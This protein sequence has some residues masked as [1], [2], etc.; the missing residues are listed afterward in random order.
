MAQLQ[1]IRS[2][3]FGIIATALVALG[4][5]MFIVDPSEIASAFQNMSSKYDVGEIGGKNITYT[6][7][8]EDVDRLS[9]INE[10]LTG[11]RSLNAEQQAQT[12]DAAWQ[13]LIYKHLFIKNAEKAGISVGAEELVDLTSGNNI[14][15]L[16]AQ[17]P[18]FFD[19][20]GAYS[21]EALK[22][23][24]RNVDSDPQLRNYW[25]YLQSSVVNKAY[26]EKYAS[27][28]TAGA[29]TNALELRNEIAENNTTSDVDFVMIPVGYAPDSTIVVS[30]KEI[31][32]YYEAHKKFYKQQASRDMEY[33]V[34]EVVPSAKDIDDT[35]VVIA[36]LVED[37]AA[38]EN[39]KSFLMKNS[40]R[41]YSETWY[42][43]GDL[44][45]V[46]PE[47][48]DFVWNDGK[49]VS[50][51]IRNKN[52][53]YVAKV[54]DSKMLPDSAYVKHILLQGENARH[55]ADSLCAVVK[56]GGNFS[57]LA[58]LYSIDTD[59][60]ADGEKGSLGWLTQTRMWPGFESV[61]TTAKVGEPFVLDTQYGSHVVLV[62]RKT[63]PVAKKQVAILEK[64]ALAS[65]GTFNEFYAKANKFATIANGSYANY[66]AA[67]DSLGVYSHPVNTMLESS[68]KLGA[69]DNTK[70]IT[71]WVF[72]NKPGKVSGIITVDNNYFFIAAVK[73]VHEEGFAK[74]S[75]VAE[76]IR[77]QLYREKAVEKKAAEIAEQ[78]EGL[79]TMAEIAEKLG[80]SVSS[81]NDVAFASMSSYG[82]DPNFI[83]AVST[84]PEGEIRTCKGNIGVYVFQVKGR[85]T[86]AF[87]TEDDARARDAQ[88][89]AYNVQGIIPVMMEAADVKDNRARFF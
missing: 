64:D 42:K 49:G 68:D 66:R 27:L 30:D 37:F 89:S 8:K 9:S 73:A 15:T 25:N 60:A 28:F 65:K 80:T 86:G 35:R 76:K 54:V 17:N 83:G 3:V 6:D 10:M 62:T 61:L 18:V 39:M 81:Q 79:G 69:I 88:M 47:I 67:V 78:I 40:D 63:A 82:L 70:E 1:T 44:K 53:F 11:G 50:E 57:G 34:F 31:K 19:E 29:Y 84:A 58:S 43:K 16:I 52:N 13:D 21:A 33:V 55:Q 51:I 7:F 48:D 12:R 24:V 26:Y 38:A 74:V 71:R 56:K 59:N 4:L 22:K 5:L 36:D 87:F 41:S 14:S 32:D 20:S 45:S 23:F 77:P 75:E 2:G 46:A 72:D 85:D